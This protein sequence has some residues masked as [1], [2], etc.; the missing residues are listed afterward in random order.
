MNEKDQGGRPT[1]YDATFNEQVYKLC[2]VG[3][4]DKDL[5]DFFDV[6]EATINNWKLEHPRFLESIKKGKQVADSHVAE[7]LYQRAI[8]YQYTE[9]KTEQENNKTKNTQIV[10]TVVPDPTAQIFWL[11]N[12]QPQKWRDAKNI[13]HTTNGEAIEGY[14]KDAIKQELRALLSDTDD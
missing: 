5:A 1:K 8:G 7:K 6:C 2:L 9:T 10:K 13:D 11:K 12:R 3:A 4:T 14:T